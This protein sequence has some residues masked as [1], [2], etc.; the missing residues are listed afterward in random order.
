MNYFKIVNAIGLST[1]I[2]NSL[3]NLQK[4]YKSM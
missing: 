2:Q 3:F 4:D 1:N